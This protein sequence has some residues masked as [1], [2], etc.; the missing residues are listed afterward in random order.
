MLIAG[1]PGRLRFAQGVR[2]KADSPPD[3]AGSCPVEALSQSG[4]PAGEFWS[5][6]ADVR[7]RQHKILGDSLE[8]KIDSS[9]SRKAGD[10]SCDGIERSDMDE[11]VEPRDSGGYAIA[12]VGRSNVGRGLAPR[13]RASRPADLVFPV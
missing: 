4:D 13:R 5:T 2:E 9:P 1:P 12:G 7:R 11:L 3:R 10:P 8:R 6:L